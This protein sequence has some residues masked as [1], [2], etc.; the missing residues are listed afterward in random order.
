MVIYLRNAIPFSTVSKEYLLASSSPVSL[1]QTQFTARIVTYDCENILQ[2]NVMNIGRHRG[3][4]VDGLIDCTPMHDEAMR[5]P[6]GWAPPGWSVQAAALSHAVAE[7]CDWRHDAIVSVC[8][9]GRARVRNSRG[10]WPCVAQLCRSLNGQGLHGF[11]L[12]QPHRR[13]LAARETVCAR[14]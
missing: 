10:G 3:V 5:H 6:R 8:I 13:A 12:R 7:W 2:H 14:S 11:E 4:F 1:P 9:G